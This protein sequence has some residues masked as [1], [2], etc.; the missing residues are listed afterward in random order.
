MLNWQGYPFIVFGA[1]DRCRKFH[2]LCFALC[3]HE[4]TFDYTFVFDTM[5]KSVQKSTGSNFE[6]NIVISDAADAIC[7]AANTIFPSAELVMC[8]VHVLRNVD[9]QKFNGKQNKKRILKDIGIL[10]L[11]PSRS[12]FKKNVKLFLRKWR[13]EEKEF[14]TYFKSNWINKHCNWY[15]S[16][17]DYTPSTN[18]NVEG[19][20][21]DF[22]L[23]SNSESA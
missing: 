9:K 3:S 13:K 19:K 7:N 4:T 1:I 21:F 8:Y 22:L 10:Q 23:L 18:N 20:F 2:P 6:P 14:T 11:S 15:E 17:A 12:M 5:A 16:F